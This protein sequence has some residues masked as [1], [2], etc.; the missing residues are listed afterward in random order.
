MGRFWCFER[1]QYI[2]R[3]AST[4]CALAPHID[5]LFDTGFISF[6]ERRLIVSRHLDPKVLEKWSISRD[7]D[8]GTF[9]QKQAR[10]LEYHRDVVLRR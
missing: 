2:R 5:H 7:V 10:F 4:H 9:N 3:N 1:R 8:V 6:D